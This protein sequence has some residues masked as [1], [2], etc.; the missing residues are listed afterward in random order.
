MNDLNK[1]GLK[2]LILIF[3][4]RASLIASLKNSILDSD[5]KTSIKLIATNLI[6]N[7]KISGSF[8]FLSK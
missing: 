3:K 2:H 4:I 8:F 5:S 6:A 7:G 1:I